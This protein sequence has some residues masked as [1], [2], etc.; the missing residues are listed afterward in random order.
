MILPIRLRP[1]VV[2]DLSEAA[3]WYNDRRRGLGQEFVEAA[4]TAFDAIAERPES[5]PVVHKGVRRALMKRFPFAIYFRNE[6]EAIVVFVVIHTA[7]SQR[8]WKRRLR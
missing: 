6:T 3:A 1:E 8:A 5:F 4:Y 7:R 2:I